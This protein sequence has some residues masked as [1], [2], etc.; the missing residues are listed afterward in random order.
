MDNEA[1][2]S[3]HGN[4]AAVIGKRSQELEHI[5]LHKHGLCLRRLGN[6]KRRA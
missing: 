6:F 1:I 2:N 4:I 5:A 3:I